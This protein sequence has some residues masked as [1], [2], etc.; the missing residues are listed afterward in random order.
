MNVHPEPTAKD[1]EDLDYAIRV[2]ISE[3]AVEYR[4]LWKLIRAIQDS[5][6]AAGFRRAVVPEPEGMVTPEAV[7]RGWDAIHGVITQHQ[8]ERALRAALEAAAVVPVQTPPEAEVKG[9]AKLSENSASPVPSREAIARRLWELFRSSRSAGTDA[10]WEV[11]KSSYWYGNADAVLA[12]W[13]TPTGPTTEQ[14]H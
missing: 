10:D 8:M 1:R 5:V 2:P 12:L 13:G 6:L 3:L 14:E 11:E 4:P 7:K 9:D